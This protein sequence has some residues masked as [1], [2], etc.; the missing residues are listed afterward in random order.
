MTVS[1]A[2]GKEENGL[3]MDFGVGDVLDPERKWVD[4]GGQVGETARDLSRDL[5]T[6]DSG[7]ANGPMGS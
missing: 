1:T 7:A 6:G 5:A 2:S 3:V 4:E